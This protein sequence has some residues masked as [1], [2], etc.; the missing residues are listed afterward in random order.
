MIDDRKG[1]PSRE[2][3]PDF[4]LPARFDESARA[5]AQPVQP[6]PQRGVSVWI[7]R[8]RFARQVLT[9]RTKGLALVSVSGLAIGTLG[10]SMLVKER[11]SSTDAASVI[12]EPNAEASA[13]QE[14]ELNAG[15]GDAQ[16]SVLPLRSAGKTTSRVRKRYSRPLA[17][18]GQ[19]SYRA[20]VV[21]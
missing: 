6:I 2:A 5:N 19:R 9:R 20:A 14:T 16:V 21:R 11:D 7:Q 3:E 1:L 4:P 12:E 15:T 8:A 18:H 13:A 17:Q 10:G